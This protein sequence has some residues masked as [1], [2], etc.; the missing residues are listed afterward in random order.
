MMAETK[1]RSDT[2]RRRRSSRA[3]DEERLRRELV[4]E[5]E[6]V[7]ADLRESV[8]VFR[9]RLEGQLTQVQDILRSPDPTDG[10]TDR[11]ARIEALATMLEAVRDLRVKPEK[12]RRRDFKRFEALIESLIDQVRS[13]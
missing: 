7:R 9:V 5:L 12:G 1:D 11:N 4:A 3:A 8:A 13:W 10:D 2:P 6:R